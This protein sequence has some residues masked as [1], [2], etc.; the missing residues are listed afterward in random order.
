MV[1]IYGVNITAIDGVG[2]LNGLK[3]LSEC[4]N[5]QEIKQKFKSAKRFTNWMSL[6]PNNKITGDRIVSSR[7]RRNNNRAAQAFRMSAMTLWNNK[8]PLGEFYRR[9][10]AKKG[11]AKAV[12]ATAR[13]LATIFYHMVTKQQEYNLELIK[14]RSEEFEKKKAKKLARILK[15]MG[16]S[17]VDVDGQLV[18]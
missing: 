12:T 17:V 9:I 18:D 7:T 13:K 6:C 14:T 10:R 3:I 15:E 11:E 8:G 16:F 2:A 5:G 1:D 4:G